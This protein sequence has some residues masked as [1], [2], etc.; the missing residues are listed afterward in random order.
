MRYPRFPSMWGLR[1]AGGLWDACGM[2]DRCFANRELWKKVTAKEHILVPA[3]V[4]RPGERGDL[5]RVAILC[6]ASGLPFGV[7]RFAGNKA[8]GG[9]S[10]G[11]AGQTPS[12]KN[13]K[14]QT[15]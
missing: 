10:D 11:G 5:G 8:A 7:V 3:A 12:S 15:V 9:R 6:P 4:Q 13:L 14:V 2:G 1:G